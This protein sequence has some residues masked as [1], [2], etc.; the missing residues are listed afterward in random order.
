[1]EVLTGFLLGYLAGAESRTKGLSALK[2]AVGKIT[3]SA[4]L[5]SAVTTG[6]SSASGLVSRL[7]SGRG[8][9]NEITRALGSLASSEELRGVVSIGVSTASGI[10]FDLVGRGK[11]LASRRGGLSLAG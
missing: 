3:S 4:E 2:D 1:M 9:S 6:M 7:S 5:Q 8:G 11:E 10:V